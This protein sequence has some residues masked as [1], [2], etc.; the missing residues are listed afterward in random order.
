LKRPLPLEK[1]QRKS[2]GESMKKDLVVKGIQYGKSLEKTEEKQ[3]P[4]VYKKYENKKMAVLPGYWIAVL[5]D[6][7]DREILVD[8]CLEDCPELRV[9]RKHMYDRDK[10]CIREQVMNSATSTVPISRYFLARF[11]LEEVL[12][13]RRGAI[14]RLR[15]DNERMLR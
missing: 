12:P 6:N 11:V 9:S 8:S 2:I 5:L 4:A 7:D 3:L 13:D 14:Y 15:G 10:V 1:L